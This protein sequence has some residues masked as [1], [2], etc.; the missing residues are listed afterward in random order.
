MWYVPGNENPD[1]GVPSVIQDLFQAVHITEA[2]AH[3]LGELSN[4]I[5]RAVRAYVDDEKI[6]PFG[7]RADDGPVDCGP[8][9]RLLELV[10]QHHGRLFKNRVGLVGEI[11]SLHARL[12][13]IVKIPVDMSPGQRAEAMERLK[14]LD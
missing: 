11:N 1:Y 4:S 13:C 10:D 9:A 14:H 12:Q 5:V 3:G 2:S 8:P 7:C 6:S